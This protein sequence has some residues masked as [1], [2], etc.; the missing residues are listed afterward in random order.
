MLTISG[1][2]V[3]ASLLMI[4]SYLQLNEGTNLRAAS[5]D[6]IRIA[7]GAAVK[8][9]SSSLEGLPRLD[10]GLTTISSTV[11]S[12][13]EISVPASVFSKEID[14]LVVM[15][16]PFD[17]CS[18]WSY[19]VTGLPS[20]V[21][22]ECDYISSSGKKLQDTQRG[23]YL[24]GKATQKGAGRPLG[25]GAVAGIAIAIFVL[26]VGILAIPWYLYIVKPGADAGGGGGEGNAQV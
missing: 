18:Q 19:R 2:S 23:L 8:F 26:I 12:A 3:E 13:L 20:G 9:V 22:A 7:N 14:E 11:P 6:A 10:L 4:D 25:A 17:S 21:R 15:G 5:Y 24:R 1:H 16:T